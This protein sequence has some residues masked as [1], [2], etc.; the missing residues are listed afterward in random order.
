MLGAAGVI[1]LGGGA[2]LA[3]GV[4][5][6]L[7]S[8]APLAPSAAGAAKSSNW[9]GYVGELMKGGSQK[10]TS[11]A[12]TWTVP[13]VTKTSSATYSSA[14]IGID[15]V[16]NTDLI[17]TGTEQD[18]AGGKAVYR[19]WWE[20]LPAAETVIPSI[21]VSPG[22]QM[23]AN[24]KLTSGTNWTITLTDVTTGKSFSIVKKYT[25]PADSAE[26][27]LEAPTVGGSIATLAHYGSTDFNNAAVAVNGGP[28]GGANLSTALKVKMVQGGKVVSTP[29]KPNSAGVGFGVAYGTKGPP[30]PPNPSHATATRESRR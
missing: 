27:V 12:G 3:A 13:T 21:K 14:W 4:P 5:I 15:G 24:I 22:D 2:P 1:V 8:H 18:W 29:G 7:E 16:Q 9:S 23:S 10:L 26:W 20:I 17:Q 6:A 25:G 11:I 30:P 28:S 19:A